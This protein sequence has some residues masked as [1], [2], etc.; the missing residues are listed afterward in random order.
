M[1]TSRQLRR[2][3]SCSGRRRMDWQTRQ[4]RRLFGLRV[5]TVR[6]DGNLRQEVAQRARF[7]QRRLCIQRQERPER[8]VPETGQTIS[9]RGPGGI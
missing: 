6:T 2:E 5:W 4:V 9:K 8:V 3:S 1:K 7:R